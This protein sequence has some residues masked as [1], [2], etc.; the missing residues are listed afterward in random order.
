MNLLPYLF[1]M[2]FSSEFFFNEIE[3]LPEDERSSVD[4]DD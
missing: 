4:I 3:I 2:M 1:K